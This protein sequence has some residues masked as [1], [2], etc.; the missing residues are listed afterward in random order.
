M[1]NAFIALILF[2]LFGLHTWAQTPHPDL[3][4]AQS[5]GGA[6]FDEGRDIAIDPND[7][8]IT[9]GYYQQTVDFDPG[10]GTTNF[11]AANDDDIFIQKTDSAGNLQWV[12]A[13]AGADDDDQASG[14]TT[15]ASGNIYV[16]GFFEGTVDFDPSI[17]VTN[18]TSNGSRDIFVMALSPAGALLWARNI[19]GTSSD[20]GVRITVENGGVY[21]TGVFRSTVD[22]DPG[23]GT[24]ALTSSGTD[25]V[26]ILRL[27]FNGNLVWA[28]SL[29]GTGF[30]QV[31]D[32]AVDANGNVYCAG[33]FTSTIDFDPG[34]GVNSETTDLFINDG[35][36]LKLDNNGDFEWVHLINDP[37]TSVNIGQND[38]RGISFAPN[39]N[40]NICG[41]FG[42]PVDFDNN[43]GTAILS[44]NGSQDAYVQQLDTN[45]NH[46]W[47]KGYGGTSLDT[48]DDLVTDAN[49]SIHVVGNFRNTVDFG[50]SGNGSRTSAGNADWFLL[51]LDNSGN[52]LALATHG[53]ST[54]DISTGVAIDGAGSC[55]VTG[56]FTG[57]VD[58]DP[59]S[60]TLFLSSFTSSDADVFVQ[61][62]EHCLP[63]F[64]T[65]VQ[66]SCTG[67]FT[68]ID[69]MTYTSSNNTA[70]HTLINA[71]GCD[72]IVTLD[73]TLGTNNTATDAV[74]ACDSFTWIDG[75]TYTSSNN[76]ATDTL[77]NV[78][79]CDSVVTLNLT[80]LNS[81]TGTDVVSACDSFTWID[82]VTYTSSNNT[83]MHTLMNAAGCD[84][85]VTLNLTILNSTTGTDVVTACDSFTWIDGMTYTSSNNT[86]VD[87][88]VNS[89]GCDSVVT[90]NLTILNST[91]GTDVVTA[92]DSFTWIDGMTYTSSNN[93]AVDTLVNASGCDSVVTLNL[94]ILNSTSGTDVV[95]ACD[96]YT[97]IDGMTY[98]S[99]N[100]TAMD[101]LVNAAGCDSVVTLNLTILNSTTGTDLVTA[102]DSFTW[103]DGIT[104]TSSNNTATQTLTNVAGC[105][106][107]VTL[108]L[109]ILNSNTGTDVVT[110]CDSFT[111]INGMTYTSSNS[112]AMDTLLNAAGCDSVVTLNLTILNSTTGT[113]VVTACDSFTWI[114][115]MTYTSSNNTA[116]DTLV[117]AA[118][119]D[120]VVT[121]N[122]TILNSTTGTDVVTACDTFTWI[123][124]VTYTS[125]NNTATDTLTNAVGCDSIVTL[126]L[127]I[128][129]ATSFTEVVI[130]CDT[131][132]WIDGVT[133]TSSNNTATVTL[134]NAAG[135][136]SLVTLDLTINTVD[137][138]VTVD[139]FTIT[140]D[141]VDA[142]Y[143]W[144]DCTTTLPL[145]GETNQSLEVD[146]NG[147][148]AVAIAKNGC[149]DTSECVT[150]TG[151]GISETTWGSEIRVYPNPTR[152]TVT[153]ELGALQAQVSLHNAAGQE[154][155]VPQSQ[156]QGQTSLSL[157]A[158][159]AGVYLVRIQGQGQQRVMRLVKQ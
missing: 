118:G 155:V 39:G 124:G 147:E 52:E 22:F 20:R 69:G 135:C 34:S 133:Y 128:L 90:L 159:S 101:T 104:Y 35:F 3:I 110:A 82:G 154:L 145:D 17:A 32:I 25:D 123:D 127:T 136:D 11:T 86:A 23:V 91:T 105:D 156:Q 54:I 115:G 44:S 87:T 46:I 88:L 73:L 37:T 120:S 10:P 9:V 117:N 41:A 148:Y 8:V 77:M 83:A 24:T 60:D 78:A 94:T 40:V 103:I 33:Y 98:T 12:V 15:D 113:D 53:N 61:K 100:N 4:R 116:V 64:S 29:E 131:F 143:Q 65:D 151:V 19:G 130:A 55:Y 112:T 56:A 111:W 146:A 6:D 140:A 14:V 31:N 132:T 38:V 42:M 43:T 80:I 95:T 75:V 119:C 62:F 137:P 121:L 76:T 149:M 152:N 49:G 126:D 72:S 7:N 153:I 150:I 13:P 114:D 97:W 16:T 1:K 129:N 26:F 125:S 36:L 18:L 84:S 85:V 51:T 71:A 109:T 2:N 21:V 50:F 99:S 45:G 63:S 28:K 141:E 102:C 30:D 108:D 59:G 144:F 68:W 79:G 89:A 138:A 47:V 142:A 122:L 5:F 106:S 92:C 93:I 96:S 67:S 58:F 81:N 66:F 74:T 158:L 48:G 139:G 70:T 157:E 107:V 57:T 134:T 27:D